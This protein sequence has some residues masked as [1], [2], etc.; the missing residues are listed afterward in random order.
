MVFTKIIPMKKLSLCIFLVLM[1]SLFTSHSFAETIPKNDPVPDGVMY[2]GINEEQWKI[3][4]KIGDPLNCR[5][6]V[7]DFQQI[8]DYKII[9]PEVLRRL[10]G[11]FLFVL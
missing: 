7:Y 2:R 4:E 9:G 11:V 6:K 1:F 3:I 10:E 5:K 8:K